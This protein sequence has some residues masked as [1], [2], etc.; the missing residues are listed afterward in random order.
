MASLGVVSDPLQSTTIWDPP[1]RCEPCDDDGHDE[2]AGHL[3]RREVIYGS[4]ASL[5]G[6]LGI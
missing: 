4:F 3:G 2:H 5:I 1:Q 6:A